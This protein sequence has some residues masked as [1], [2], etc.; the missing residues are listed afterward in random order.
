MRSSRPCGQF[1]EQEPGTNIDP[2]DGVGFVEPDWQTIFAL[3]DGDPEQAQRDYGALAHALRETL[4]WIIPPGCRGR[5]GAIPNVAHRAIALLWTLN[6]EYFGG[7]SMREVCRR[8]GLNYKT[9]RK[10]TAEVRR[11]F[12]IRNRWQV[13]GQFK[14]TKMAR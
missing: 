3:L 1:D 2:L 10:H 9:M 7:L 12:G 5:T 8:R 6:P 13:Y 11:R 14:P 4:Q